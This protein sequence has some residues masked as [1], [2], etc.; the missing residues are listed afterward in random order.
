MTN[1]REAVQPGQTDILQA[2]VR[3]DAQYD[4]E[5]DPDTKGP[6]EH[7]REKVGDLLG[8]DDDYPQQGEV[9]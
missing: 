8:K 3:G 7:V 6:V 5:H 9:R 1:E 4:P 2:E